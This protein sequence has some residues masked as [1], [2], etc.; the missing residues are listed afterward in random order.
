MFR[1]L[2]PRAP[3]LALPLLA[4]LAGCQDASDPLA[5]PRPEFAQGDNN[6]WT[7][8]TLVDPGDGT[9]DD[10][11]CTLREAIEA[12]TSG[13]TIVFASGLQGDI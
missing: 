4:A 5:A 11:E 9:C 13:S 12:A 7:V 1:R 2:A 3:L 8:N 10:T 6:T